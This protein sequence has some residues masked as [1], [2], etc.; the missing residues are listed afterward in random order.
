MDDNKISVIIPIYKV[1]RYLKKCL[2]SVVSQTYKNLEIILIDDGSP[3]NCGKICD[4]YASVDA[5][6]RAIHQENRGLSAAYNRGLDIASGSFIAFVDSDD[7]IEPDF[8]GHLMGLLESHGADISAC[9]FFPF[10]ADEKKPAITEKIS[11]YTGLESIEKVRVS[12]CGKIYKRVLFENL[13][14]PVDRHPGD[15]FLTY[16]VMYRA[17]KVVVTNLM[18]FNYLRRPD[19][20]SGLAPRKETLH[21]LDAF[22]EKIKFL[23]EKGHPGHAAA[24]KKLLVATLARL[25]IFFRETGG[26]NGAETAD[27]LKKQLAQ[28]VKDCVNDRHLNAVKKSEV[29]FYGI[30]PKAAVALADIKHKLEG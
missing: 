24:A 2:D 20:V 23:E 1:E 30:M 10:M 9:A 3:D 6:V 12:P 27:S 28:A 8:C 5:R 25:Y 19:G 26:Q 17:K 7:W 29:L 14:F 4:E 22:R 11:V 18:L 13:R 15:I 16:K 21:V